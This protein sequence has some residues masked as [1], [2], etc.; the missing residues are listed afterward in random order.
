MLYFLSEGV[1]TLST[2]TLLYATSNISY[3]LLIV[4]GKKAV[5]T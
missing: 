1:K 5:L 2:P 3:P 4:T